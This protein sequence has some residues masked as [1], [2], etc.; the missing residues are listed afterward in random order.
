MLN[1]CT[2]NG[3]KQTFRALLDSD[4]MCSLITERAVTLLNATR[5]SSNVQILGINQRISRNKGQTLETY[6]GVTITKDHPMIILDKLTVNLPRI[7]VPPD[8]IQ[9]T[10]HYDL[11]DPSY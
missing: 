4:S 7:P 8:V 3:I 10:K 2:S 9:L 6:S 1:L 11:A 5:Q